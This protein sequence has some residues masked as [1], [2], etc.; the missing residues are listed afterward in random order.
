MRIVVIGRTNDFM[1]VWFECAFFCPALFFAKFANYQPNL[2][3]LYETWWLY[4]SHSLGYVDEGQWTPFIG[5]KFCFRF[6]YSI[7]YSPFFQFI[8]AVPTS[9]YYQFRYDEE[10]TMNTSLMSVIP[11]LLLNLITTQQYEL[12]KLDR[13]QLYWHT[14]DSVKQSLDD[15]NS[16]IYFFFFFKDSVHIGISGSWSTDEVLLNDLPFLFI[17]KFVQNITVCI[18]CYSER[19]YF[20]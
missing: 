20:L 8:V 14:S 7:F 18:F 15:N 13:F 9:T 2:M 19:I 17:M 12:S 10:K 4:E 1:N 6:S 16:I 3:K 11:V 5:V